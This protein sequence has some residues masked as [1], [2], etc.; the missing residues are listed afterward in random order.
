MTQISFFHLSNNPILLH[1]L[2]SLFS[3]VEK[4][5]VHGP[6]SKIRLPS[7]VI[8]NLFLIGESHGKGSS[9]YKR[10]EYVM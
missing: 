4:V 8:L 6:S 2:P 5:E 1:I 9:L 10:V 3:T 7:M